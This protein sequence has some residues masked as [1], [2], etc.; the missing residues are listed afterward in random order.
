MN[1]KSSLKLSKCWNNFTTYINLKN[2]TKL[3]KKS[4]SDSYE[5]TI[6]QL[7]LKGTIIPIPKKV[8]IVKR[9]NLKTPLYLLFYE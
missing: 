3:R 9:R 4:S 5:K 6:G 8:A 7:Y 2:K 1:W